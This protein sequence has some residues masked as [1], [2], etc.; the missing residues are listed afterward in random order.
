[1]AARDLPRTDSVRVR[2]PHYRGKSVIPLLSWLI[3]ERLTNENA[4]V[5][6]Y[7]ERQQ[8]PDSCA[9]LL[10]NIGWLGV[11]KQREGKLVRIDCLPP[12]HAQLPEP[13]RFSAVVTGHE[14]SFAADY[15]VFSPRQVDDG[16]LMLAEVASRHSP[17]E[18]LADIGTGY[19]PLAIALVR[20][21]LAERAVVTDVDS[22]ALWLAEL[23]A[24]DNGVALETV[25]SPDPADVQATPLTVCNVPTHL[26]RPRS[27]ELMNGLAQRAGKSQ[28]VMIVVHKSLEN[29]FAKYLTGAGLTVTS[30][31]GIAHVVLTATG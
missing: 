28:T 12:A 19:G 11:K 15:G 24:A 20:A 21:G 22:V 25:F 9:A 31:P 10:D 17:G 27:A 2:L 7:L 8:G 26:D 16:T 30:E 29:R 23:N 18:I 5:S 3:A 4:Q 13:R 14:L 1:M 6:W